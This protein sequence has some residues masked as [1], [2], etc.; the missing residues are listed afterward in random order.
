MDYLMGVRGKDFIMIVSD[1]TAVQQI[2]TIKHDEVPQRL[3][4]GITV[5]LHT[6]RNNDDWSLWRLRVPSMAGKPPA[7][8]APLLRESHVLPDVALPCAVVRSTQSIKRNCF[9]SLCISDPE[10]GSGLAPDRLQCPAQC[11]AVLPQQ[12]AASAYSIDISA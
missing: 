11:L 5:R 3:H 9:R 10:W 6:I 2:I 12:S 8:Y 7:L 1:T 4:K